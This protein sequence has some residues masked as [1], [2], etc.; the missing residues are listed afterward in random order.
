MNTPDLE[1]PGFDLLSPPLSPTFGP[2]RDPSFPSLVLLANLVSTAWTYFCVH[3]STNRRSFAYDFI[4]EEAAWYTLWYSCQTFAFL[5]SITN[6]SLAFFTLYGMRDVVF[7]R[8]KVTRPRW[9][10]VGLVLLVICG[11]VAV[12]PVGILPWRFTMVETGLHDEN[13]WIHC[14]L[15]LS[16]YESFGLIMGR[17]GDI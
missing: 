10:Q 9:H 5:V 15:L 16:G 17:E 7:E 6:V 4:H 2:S 12:V 14:K 3:S 1:K 8:I 11:V 13:L